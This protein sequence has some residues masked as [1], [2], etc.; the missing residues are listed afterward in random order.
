MTQCTCVIIT[1]KIIQS[2]GLDSTIIAEYELNHTSEWMLILA[3][4]PSVTDFVS[5]AGIDKTTH[6]LLIAP[7]LC[8][9]NH[10]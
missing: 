4:A 5:L 10:A 7:R 2:T 8:K 1:R 9:T 6:N 3:P